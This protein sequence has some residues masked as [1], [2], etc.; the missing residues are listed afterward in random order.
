MFLCKICWSSD[1][2]SLRREYKDPADR[3][4]FCP[5]IMIAPTFAVLMLTYRNGLLG[6]WQVLS[7]PAISAH[8][9]LING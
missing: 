5:Y 9:Y 8:C 7:Y 4:G 6:S 1:E 2:L 3:R